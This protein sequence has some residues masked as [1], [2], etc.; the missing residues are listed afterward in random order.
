[1]ASVQRFTIEDFFFCCWRWRGCGGVMPEEE[2][3]EEGREAVE[4]ERRPN[5]IA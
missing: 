3:E 2:E 4:E 1:L 5:P